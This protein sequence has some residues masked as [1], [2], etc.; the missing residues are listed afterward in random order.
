MDVK[1]RCRRQGVRVAG[2]A[3]NADGSTR[4]T[5]DGDFL[6]AVETF[7]ETHVAHA[8]LECLQRVF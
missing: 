8:L 7:P 6:V 2:H 4:T 1:T 5:L 3:V